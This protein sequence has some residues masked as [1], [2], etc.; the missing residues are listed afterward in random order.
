MPHSR[1]DE[2]RTDARRNLQDLAREIVLNLG[3]S[4][5][6]SSGIGRSWQ[7]ITK[8]TGDCTAIHSPRRLDRP[9]WPKIENA[10]AHFESFRRK[11][12]SDNQ[13][14]EA[15]P[16]GEFCRRWQA[17]REEF[18]DELSGNTKS[19][20]KHFQL[21]LPLLSTEDGP[22]CEKLS[23][24]DVTLMKY[25]DCA[26]DYH[27][28]H[29]GCT[30][31][32]PEGRQSFQLSREVTGDPDGELSLETEWGR[33]VAALLNAQERTTALLLSLASGSA[34][35]GD[36]SSDSGTGEFA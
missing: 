15:F 24:S 30:G 4:I 13:W 23:V 29:S 26:Q 17:A 22:L 2:V 33:L 36:T 28:Y 16:L 31:T 11:A 1:I 6:F 19:T 9:D 5:S 20:R 14:A 32:L 34:E 10:E 8:Y 35:S 27:C 25:N 12:L 3:D 18:Y 7:V 21:F